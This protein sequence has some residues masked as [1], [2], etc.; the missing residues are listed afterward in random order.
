M[1]GSIIV[2]DRHRAM[3]KEAMEYLMDEPISDAEVERLAYSYVK[4]DKPD[5]SYFKDVDTLIWVMGHVEFTPSE[6]AKKEYI[7]RQAQVL[8]EDSQ[9]VKDLRSGKSFIP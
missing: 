3:V 9:T 1:E 2:T 4:S 7:D 5:E 8:G 6:E